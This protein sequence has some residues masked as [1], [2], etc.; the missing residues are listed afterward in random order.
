MEV[1]NNNLKVIIEVGSKI[2][3][4]PLAYAK[5]G[6]D[7]WIFEPLSKNFELLKHNV[8]INNLQDKIRCINIGVGFPGK[9]R[10]PIGDGKHETADFISLKDVFVNY[11]IEHCDL[12]NLDCGGSEYSIIKDMDDDLVGLIDQIVVKFHSKKAKK[13]LVEIL[14]KWYKEI[15]NN[16]NEH[17]FIK[18]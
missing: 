7:I 9:I 15:Y 18:K 12:L 13:E 6:S 2:E 1:I 10:L 8:E 14:L 17:V 16:K 5:K 11:K 4:I 3:T